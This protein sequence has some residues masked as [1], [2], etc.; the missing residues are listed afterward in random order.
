MKKN[1]KYIITIDIGGTKTNIG[2]FFE[3]K[4]VKLINFPTLKFGPDNINK[5][6]EILQNSKKNILV[7]CLSLTG[8]INSKGLWN[9]INKKTLGNFV[10]YPIIKKLN[11]FL[12]VPVYALG[13]TQAAALGELYYG[14]GKNLSNFF[15]LTISTGIGGSIIQNKNLFNNKISDIGSLGHNVIKF[16]GR[17]CGCGRKG[18]LE[19]YS[20]GNALIK[21]NKIKKCRDTKELLTKFKNHTQTINIVNQAVEMIIQSILNVNNL[22]RI[23]NFI[24]GGSV[25]SNS[26]FYK[27]IKKEL[28]KN[29]SQV[30]IRKTELNSKA[31]LYG[32]FAYINNRLF[33]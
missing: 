17:L 12:N 13:D 16:N 7:I 30:K 2:Y 20:S 9:P 26:F 27:K 4:L 5:I 22:I 25:G 33:L 29:L 8:L 31:E 28:K 24:I 6:L 32:C 21:S 10:N 1:K 18:C 15:Y 14:G 3:K 23:D 11:Y 19:A